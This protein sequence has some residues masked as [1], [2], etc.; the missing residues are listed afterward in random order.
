VNKLHS[1][2]M[3]NVVTTEFKLL[4]SVNNTATCTT[5]LMYKNTN[6]STVCPTSYRTQH[7]FNNSNINKDIATK[8]EQEYICCVRNEE[9]CVCSVPNFCDKELRVFGVGCPDGA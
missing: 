3:S 8:S 9:K 2:L 5:C 6:E 4:L 1:T 7:F